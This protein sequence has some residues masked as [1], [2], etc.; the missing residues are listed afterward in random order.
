MLYGACGFQG[1]WAFSYAL[2]MFKGPSMTLH[3]FSALSWKQAAGPDSTPINATNT[4]NIH[5][6]LQLILAG[7]IHF[8]H[9]SVCKPMFSLLNILFLLHQPTAFHCSV[10]WP[11]GMPHSLFLDLLKTS[12]NRTKSDTCCDSNNFIFNSQNIFQHRSLTIPFKNKKQQQENC[13]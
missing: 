9:L 7:V 3:S 6:T 8:W 10:N 12:P 2:R 5:K 13:L 11:V 4:A 1:A